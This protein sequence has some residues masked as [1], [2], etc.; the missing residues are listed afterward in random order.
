MRCFQAGTI[1]RQKRRVSCRSWLEGLTIR[2]WSSRLCLLVLRFGFCLSA[3]CLIHHACSGNAEAGKDW[4]FGHVQDRTE[5]KRGAELG[6][7]QSDGQR[8]HCDAERCKS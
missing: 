8:R 1:I 4:N 3:R 7:Y 5:G 6:G 2:T